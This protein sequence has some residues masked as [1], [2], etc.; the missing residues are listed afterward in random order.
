VLGH[1]QRGDE[2]TGVRLWSQNLPSRNGR[3]FHRPYRSF[4]VAANQIAEHKHNCKVVFY[5]YNLHYRY[6]L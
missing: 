6:Q 3:G 2:W 4:E 5:S 1:C